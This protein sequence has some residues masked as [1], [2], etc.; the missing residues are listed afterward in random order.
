[1]YLKR[2]NRK[3]LVQFAV[4]EFGQLDVMVNNAGVD[5]VTPILEIEDE[6]SKLFNINMLV[7]CLEFKQLLTNLLNKK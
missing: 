1:M 2:K 6:L 3:E 5:A 7:H 4:T